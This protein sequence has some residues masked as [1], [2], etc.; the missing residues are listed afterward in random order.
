MAENVQNQ[1]LNN[2]FDYHKK[3][4]NNSWKSKYFIV[5]CPIISLFVYFAC[6]DYLKNNWFGLFIDIL[7]IALNVHFS[8]LFKSDDENLVVFKE[9]KSIMETPRVKEVG[10]SVIF[11]VVYPSSEILNKIKKM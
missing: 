9:L 3:P 5:A 7:I 10:C 6:H 4:K 2:P 8:F 1:L 11:T